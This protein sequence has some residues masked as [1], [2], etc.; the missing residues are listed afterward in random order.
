[1]SAPELFDAGLQPERT[2]LSWRRTA[3]SIGAGSLVSVR[4]FPEVLG[5]AWAMV[6]GF[7][8]LL[9]AG[10]LWNEG[11]RRYR[12]FGHHVARGHEIGVGGGALFALVLFSLAFGVLA[13]VLV[14]VRVLAA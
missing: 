2:Q 14:A 9:F 3:L 5:T 11:H 13:L 8:G 6:P 7:L 4:I 12:R 1:V 10:W